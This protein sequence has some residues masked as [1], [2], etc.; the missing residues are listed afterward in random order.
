[1]NV[2]FV[3]VRGVAW[4]L[5]RQR[6]R[7]K[8]P[9]AHPR[10]IM[11]RCVVRDIAAVTAAAQLRMCCALTT[12]RFS[13]AVAACVSHAAPLAVADETYAHDDR[14]RRARGEREAGWLPQLREA[15]QN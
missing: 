1:M 14:N 10:R 9:D 15:Q 8:R 4:L 7:P 11:H 13:I 5:T 12:A 6:A 2:P 3:S